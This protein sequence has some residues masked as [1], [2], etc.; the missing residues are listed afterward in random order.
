[1]SKIKVTKTTSQGQNNSKT[2]FQDEEKVQLVIWENS[3][4]SQTKRINC[5]EIVFDI[6][7]TP[8]AKDQ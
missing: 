5:F 1:M 4:N 3:K 2:T 7:N 8:I 6:N